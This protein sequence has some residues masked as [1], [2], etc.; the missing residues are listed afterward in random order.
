MRTENQ[1]LS[2]HRA[3]RDTEEATAKAKALTTKDTKGHEE[4]RGKPF[5]PRKTDR[6][7]EE[8]DRNS[9]KKKEKKKAHW[10]APFDAAISGQ[11]RV[12]VSSVSL[13]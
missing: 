6:N 5:S 4:E 3:H 8:N 12:S 9:G 1:D 7:A 13:W 11:Y 10:I 2:H